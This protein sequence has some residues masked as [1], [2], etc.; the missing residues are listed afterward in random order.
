MNDQAFLC[1]ENN[2]RNG[3]KEKTKEMKEKSYMEKGNPQIVNNLPIHSLL[4]NVFSVWDL[5][6]LIREVS[7]S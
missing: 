2:L 7:L 4:L 6:Q 3:L 1:E 5:P